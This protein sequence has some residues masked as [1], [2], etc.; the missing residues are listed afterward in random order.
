MTVSELKSTV[1]L[2]PGMAW[3]IIKAERLLIHEDHVPNYIDN[4]LLFY[5]EGSLLL[6]N[7]IPEWSNAKPKQ[8]ANYFR[9]SIENRSTNFPCQKT[10]S[11]REIITIT[12]NNAKLPNFRT[13]YFSQ[14]TRFETFTNAK[15]RPY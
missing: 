8:F 3:P 6:C 10:W 13:G 11:N 7:C 2:L 4:T 9:H 14:V 5:P 1:Y 12:G 15:H